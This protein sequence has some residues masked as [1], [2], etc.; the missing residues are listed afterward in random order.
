MKS[1]VPAVLVLS[2][3]IFQDD[4]LSLLRRQAQEALRDGKIE[5]VVEIVR[6]AGQIDSVEAA[7][8]ALKIVQKSKFDPVVA[9]GAYEAAINLSNNDADRAFLTKRLEALH[10]GAE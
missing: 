4:S 3:G 10:T 8:F 9:A 6:F 5:R 7:E 1:L 2:L